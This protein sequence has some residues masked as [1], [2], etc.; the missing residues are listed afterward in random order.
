[1]LAGTLPR[2]TAYAPSAR[3]PDAL[4]VYNDW[5]AWSEQ[6][7]VDGIVS[8]QERVRLPEGAPVIPEDRITQTTWDIGPI[9]EDAPRCPVSVF[10]PILAFRPA[11]GGSWSMRDRILEPVS[12][13]EQRRRAAMDQG[14]SELI[15]HE[16]YMPLFV[17]TAGRDHGIG[18][19]PKP[20]YWK[21][22]R[23]WNAHA[24]P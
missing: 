23:A 13:I 7:G 20:E 24:S 10:H 21:A 3:F 16:G 8:V 5:S 22:I 11:G 2:R 6:A 17:D 14:A 4:R 9:V 18:A 1:M 19:C 15:L 12:F